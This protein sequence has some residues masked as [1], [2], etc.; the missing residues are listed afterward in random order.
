[1]IT[2]SEFEHMI[3]CYQCRI[4][5]RGTEGIFGGPIPLELAKMFGHTFSRLYFA[6]KTVRKMVRRGKRLVWV[7]T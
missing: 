6:D 3:W 5:T 4:D 2:W 1:M 7:K